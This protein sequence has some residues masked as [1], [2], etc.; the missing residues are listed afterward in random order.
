MSFSTAKAS[1]SGNSVVP[2][3]P[4]T[5]PTPSCLSR[6]RNARLPDITGTMVSNSGG[7]SVGN[8][9]IFSGRWPWEITGVQTGGAEDQCAHR[10]QPIRRHDDFQR[11]GVEA[12][13]LD[14]GPDRAPLLGFE[15][16]L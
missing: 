5:I 11:R 7:R 15:L 4:N 12:V 14:R 9:Q 2:G 1:I 10:H 13:V 6:S 16:H 8:A 3:L